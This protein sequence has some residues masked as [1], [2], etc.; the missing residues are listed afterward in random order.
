MRELDNEQE[1]ETPEHFYSY[2]TRET[3]VEIN[4]YTLH[5]GF[6]KTNDGENN[7]ISLKISDDYTITFDSGGYTLYKN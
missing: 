2:C 6:P 1:Y 3:G 4:A 7:I 5:N